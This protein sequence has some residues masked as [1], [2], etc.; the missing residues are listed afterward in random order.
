MTL[1]AD[2]WDKENTYLWEDVDE[3]VLAAILA[4]GQGGLELLH[5]QVVQLVNQNRFNDSVVA[6]LRAYRLKTVPGINETT[7]K[8]ALGIIADWSQSGATLE[9]LK[10]QLL[11]VFPPWRVSAI[12]ITEVTRMFALGNELMWNA[13]GVV[14]GKQW[15]TARDEL[16][17]PLC[18]P[19]D[20][21]VTSLDG[22]FTLTSSTIADSP[23]MRNFL[24][25]RYSQE[26]AIRAANTLVKHNGITTARPPR[27]VNCRCYESPIVSEVMFENVLKGILK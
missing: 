13:S 8:R 24:G 25:S 1:P 11:V 7:R 14:S 9:S 10:T 20:G 23:Q 26:A 27:H 6:A 4:G 5:P 19:L 3:L 17:C 18:G 16:V 21:M 12:A 22:G 2:F 15:R